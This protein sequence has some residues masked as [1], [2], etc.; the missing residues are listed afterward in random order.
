V[1]ELPA[2]QSRL[3]R[4]FFQDYKQLEHK[5]VEVGHMAPAERGRQTI[6]AAVARYKTKFKKRVRSRE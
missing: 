6:S 2:H 4:R 3:V 1:S 5:P